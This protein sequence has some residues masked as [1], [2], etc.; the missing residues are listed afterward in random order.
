MSVDKSQDPALTECCNICA[1]CKRWFATDSLN[2]R[3]V[4]AP[5][6]MLVA[7]QGPHRQVL[8]RHGEPS[9]TDHRRVAPG[10]I[11]IMTS[12]PSY[13]GYGGLDYSRREV[14]HKDWSFGC[15]CLGERNPISSMAIAVIDPIGAKVLGARTLQQLAEPRRS[16]PG[17]VFG[18]SRLHPSGARPPEPNPDRL[19]LDTVIVAVSDLGCWAG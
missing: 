11:G 19:W 9:N 5:R 3:L 12:R 6:F 16:P 2:D 7:T 15:C 10:P 4:G 14:A 18:S 1:L 13:S 8:V 17:P